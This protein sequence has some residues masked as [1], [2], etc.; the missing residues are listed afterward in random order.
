VSPQEPWATRITVDDILALHQEGILRYGG[1][2]SPPA[3]GCIERS[4]GAAYN[5]ELYTQT[6][7]SRMGLCFAGC[8]LFYLTQNHC[9]TDGN[10]RIGWMAAVEVLRKFGL[11]VQATDDEACLFCLRIVSGEIERATDVSGA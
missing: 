7:D 1:D 8:L 5:A 10:K 11:T 9:F 6:E 3:S 4:L 2:Y